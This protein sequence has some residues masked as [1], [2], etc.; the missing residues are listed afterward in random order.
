VTYCTAVRNPCTHRGPHSTPPRHSSQHMPNQGAPLSG[1]NAPI[2]DDIYDR[3]KNHSRQRSLPAA[4]PH[5]R[6]PLSSP[7]NRSLTAGRNGSLPAYLL[8]PRFESYAIWYAALIAHLRKPPVRAEP[9]ISF[10]SRAHAWIVRHRLRHGRTATTRKRGARPALCWR[11]IGARVDE[12]CTERASWPTGT[13]AHRCAHH[14]R[15]Q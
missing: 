4:A 14:G 5:N 9:Q 3:S 1:D 10:S 13:R 6:N 12:L 15:C 2:V 11:A 7:R 8:A